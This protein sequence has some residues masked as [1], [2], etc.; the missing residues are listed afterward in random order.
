MVRCLI[1]VILINAFSA[2]CLCQTF[3]EKDYTRFTTINGLSD[4]D[5]TGITQDDFGYLWIS[6][7]NGLNR[8]D[9]KDMKRIYQVPGK[10]GLIA[11][12]LINI[13]SDGNRL[14]VYSSKGAQWMDVDKNRF[15][16]MRVSEGLPASPY[17]NIFYD[18]VITADK[19]CVVTS[20]TGV[21]SFD[22]T[23]KL[24]FRYDKYKDPNENLNN[25]SRY[26]RQLVKLNKNLVLHFDVKYN[27]SVYDCRKKTFLPIDD[28]EDKL[29]GLYSLKGTMAIKGRLD[30]TKFIFLDYNSWVL[31]IYDAEKDSV[32]KQ[33]PLSAWG[34]RTFSWATHWLTLNDSTAIIFGEQR[35]IHKI[36]IDPATLR[37]SYD[38][39]PLLNTQ[40]FNTFF[41]DKDERLWLGAHKGLLRYNTKP[42]VAHTVRHPSQ[43]L[44]EINN[45]LLF[46]SFF[47]SEKFLYAGTYSTLPVLVLDGDSYRIV[48][49]ISFAKLSKKYNQVWNIMHYNK[50]TLWFGT[51]QGLIWYDEKTGKFDRVTLSPDIDLI[52]QGTITLLT[53]DSKGIIWIQVNWGCGII[54][55]DPV[56]KTSRLYQL[57]DKESYLPLYAANFAAEDK[58]TNMW[59]AENGLWRW[60]RQTEKF[61]TM[62]TTY[63]GFNKENVRITW[64][65]NDE[66]GNLVFC[67]ENNG[68]LTYNPVDQSYT[69]LSTL[70][71]LQE[72]AVHAA[73]TSKKYWWAVTYN[74]VTTI[75]RT[76]K[77]ATSYSQADSLPTDKFVKAYYD[78]FKKRLLVGYENEFVWI[79]EPVNSTT[80]KLTPFYID[81]LSIGDD[82][83]IF[84]PN[85]KVKLKHFQNDIIIHFGAINLIEPG[86]NRYA[87]RI[88][89]KEWIEIGNENFLNFS[90]LSAGTYEV[91]IKYYTIANSSDETIRKITLIVSA[92]FWKQAWFIIL[93]ILSAI[94]LLILYYRSKI[95]RIRQKARIDNQMAEYEI[96][97][98]HAQ[99]NPHFI[100]NCLNSIREMI[101]NNENQQASHYLSKFAHLIRIT[102]NHSSKPFISLEQTLDYL[103]R[104]MEME[105]IRN[106]QFSYSIDTENQLP[107]DEIMIPP[108]LIQPFLENAI[109][110]GAIPGK[111]LQINVRFRKEENYLVCYVEDNGPGIEITMNNKNET[112]VTH[113]SIGIANVRERV[114]VLNEKYNLQ[115]ELIITDKSKNGNDAGTLVKLS[116]PLR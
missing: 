29:P 26:G 103:K 84:F 82:S 110:H 22:S 35:G 68:I 33:P 42:D 38:T 36:H 77:K 113:N 64:L 72:N 41:L 24:I 2:V 37:F 14:L 98:L 52:N 76:N 97:A 75:D 54:K 71:G 1:T 112:H 116:F 88:N 7:T 61:D 94:A 69:Q 39:I 111:E 106:S 81:A 47:R 18:A 104:Y 44:Y 17:Q 96:K 74:F 95:S 53:K 59:F 8:F 48:K 92:P 40:V 100:F 86:N 57:S 78:P 87:Y 12:K 56:K 73:L 21:Y 11:D 65:G 23:G 102:L 6:T 25:Y 50:D 27:M 28:Y 105:K 5:I 4:N 67:N 30:K 46:L 31:K 115:S 13:K 3:D 108:M 9:G 91:E 101:L 49:E 45:P 15:I 99:M 89:Q 109:W 62:I 10:D 63:H 107:V 43:H 60:N 16:K 90:N 58:E 80:K 66:N 114:K 83:T 19:S 79:N 55:Y 51:Q 20:F 93:L 70:N 34:R 85:D 32:Y